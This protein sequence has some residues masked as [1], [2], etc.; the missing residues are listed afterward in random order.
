MCVCVFARVVQSVAHAHTRMHTYT[1]REREGARGE[2][3]PVS[4]QVHSHAHARN[5]TNS[6]THARTQ[7]HTHTHF[8]THTHTH[9]TAN[10]ALGTLLCGV[11]DHV[12]PSVG[13]NRER[14][15]RSLNNLPFRVRLSPQEGD[16]KESKKRVRLFGCSV[17]LMRAGVNV[18]ARVRAWARACV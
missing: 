11:R 15:V 5:H 9:T 14:N 12:G 2:G 17:C 16:C 1:H 8:Y 18:Y 7:A 10:A 6:P 3:R 13:P 4:T